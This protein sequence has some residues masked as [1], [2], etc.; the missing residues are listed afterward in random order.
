LS[1][2]GWAR[3]LERLAPYQPLLRLTG[4]EPTLHPECGQIVRHVKEMGF[5]F[6]VFSNAR[7]QEPDG[8][9][10]LLA[11]CRQLECILVSLHGARAAS[12]ETFTGSR[13]SFEETIA[14]IRRATQA[15]LSV[16]TS[17]VITHD[18]YD[19][20]ADIINLDR[21]LE[22]N[23]AVFNRYI[24]APMPELEA[25]ED[26]LR[27]AVQVV[28]RQKAISGNGR[29]KFGTP[30]PHCFEPNS[31][32]GCMAGFAHVTIDPWGNVR[33]CPHVSL[34]V[35]NLLSQ[36]DLSA[37]LN[38]S[39]MTTWQKEY[40]AQC[41]ECPRQAGCF[42]GCRAEASRRPGRVD[43]LVKLHGQFLS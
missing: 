3:I 36:G 22:A 6:T 38:T 21:Q 20:I 14:N 23:H 31:S 32:N 5:P 9:L 15:G 16:T 4:G 28:E 1:V 34:V 2:D 8:L 7:W 33:P 35:G 25:S 26:E 39:A 24:G 30:I 29:V 18:N 10:K 42:A 40:R 12:H 17:T 27:V 41:A 43:P 19:E 11:G 13:G 37:I